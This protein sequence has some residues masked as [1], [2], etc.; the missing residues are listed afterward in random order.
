MEIMI[1]VNKLGMEGEVPSNVNVNFCVG[2]EWHRFPS[3]F[4]FPS[5]K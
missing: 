5:N 3:S 1:E 4:F 2:K